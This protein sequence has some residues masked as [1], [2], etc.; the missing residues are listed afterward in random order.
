MDKRV[1]HV[2]HYS[3]HFVVVL[4]CFGFLWGGELQEWRDDMKR[5]GDEWDWGARYEIHKESIKHYKYL[6]SKI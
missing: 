6:L 5:W 1:Y 3:F 4:V 2:T